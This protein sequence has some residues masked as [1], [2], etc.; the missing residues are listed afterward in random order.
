[1][2]GAAV[3]AAILAT[4]AFASGEPAA[5]QSIPELRRRI[6]IILSSTGTP[7]AGVALV[8]RD[9]PIWVDAA[10][11]ADVAGN[12]AATEDTLFPIGSIA[13]SFVAL[14]LLKL[15]QEGRIGLQDTL[16]SRAPD[17]E[18]G[19]PWE[20]TDPVR[21]VHLLEHTSGWDD[22]TPHEGN[23]IP[24]E[25]TTRREA[26]AYFPRSRTSRWRPG[27]CFSY[28]NLGVDVAAYVV[29]KIAG[30]KFED[31]VAR[32][33]FV[34]LGMADASYCEQ[35]GALPNLAT[36]YGPDGGVAHTHFNV[37]TRPAGSVAASARDMANYVEFFLNRGSFR[38]KQFLPGTAIDRMER[39]TSTY[40]AAE[41]LTIGYGLGNQTSEWGGWV[42]HGHGGAVPGALAEMDYLPGEGV[43]YAF[44]INREDGGA[45]WQ[46]E[47]LIRSYL[48]RNLKPPPAPRS[49]AVDEAQLSA[50]SGWYE[51]FTPRDESSRYLERILGVTHVSSADGQL[52][53]DDLTNGKHAFVRVAGGLYRRP[54]NSRSLALIRDQSDG[55]YFQ[56]IGGPTFRRMPPVLAALKLGFAAVTAL[57]ML[58]SVL[59]AFAWMPRNL[60][61]GPEKELFLGVRSD[62]FLATIFGTV[63]FALIWEGS[64]N[65]YARANG[66]TWSGGWISAA[67]YVAGGAFVFFSIR[68]LYRAVRRRDGGI[69]RP[70]WWHSFVTSLALAI[71]AIYLA[72]GGLR[73]DFT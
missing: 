14:S 33:W 71:W 36:C 57:L 62:P 54:D 44:M 69:A 63:V 70:V 40:A 48:T 60:V 10:G 25:G 9:G 67:N 49:A 72:Y 3:F 68:G 31:Y 47:E 56:T 58:S 24:P 17:V 22:T 42:F 35:P 41:G 6:E 18:F 26:I 8:A 43:G 30:E 51:P 27:T 46:I 4:S 29:E 61:K 21:I 53:L 7:A 34:P 52:F 64:N 73:G 66:A 50:Y 13:K 5:P 23:W 45:R 55:T 19:N 2:L 20:S 39:P 1:M 28:S 15:Q 59:L 12:R 11:L 37:L 16:R 65:Y 38:G 32:T